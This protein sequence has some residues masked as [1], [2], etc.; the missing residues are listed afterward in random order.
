VRFTIERIRT[1][2]LVAGALLLVA[3]AGFLWVGKW[4]NLLNRGDLPQ[5]LGVNIQQEA[6]GYTF[7]HAYG[8]HSQ[9][10]I[11]ASKEVQLK[12]NRVVLHDVQIE[13]Y[14]QDGKDIDRI[15]GETFEYDEK[16]GVATAQGPV[17]MLLTRPAAAP[18]A[19]AKRK[20]LPAAGA[21]SSSQVYSSQIHVKTSGVTFD[22]NSGMVTTEQQVDFSMTQGYG[23]AMGAQY[24]SQSGHLTLDQ[25]V[26]LT[27]YRGGDTVAIHAQHAEID[28]TTQLCLLRAATADYRGGQAGAAEAKLLFRTEGSA[29][30]LDTTGGF[31]LATATG[32]RLAAPVGW[33]EF[34]EHN[35][36][37][38]G[39]M[40]GGVTMDSVNALRTVHG[41]SPTAELEFT[42]AGQLR[43]AHLER[44]VAIDSQETGPETHQDTSHEANTPLHLNRTWRSPVADMDFR[45]AGQGRVELE[46]MKGTGGVAITSESRRGN[47][48]AAPSK[49]TANEVTGAFGPDSAL[50]SMTGVGHAGIEQTTATGA[51]QTGSGDRLQVE[52][53]QNREQGNKG[54]REQGSMGEAAT[55]GVSEVQSAELDGHVV[56][57][58]Q[59]AAKPGA[60]PQPAMHA[61]AGK[62]VYEGT[63]EWLHLTLSPRV[64][65]G[66]LELT[67]DKV[68]VSEQTGD[69]FAH[70]NVK[71]TWTSQGATAGDGAPGAKA[72]QNTGQG[73]VV[74]GAQGP[75]HVIAEEAQLHQSTGEATFRGH[76]RL[77]QQANSVSGPLIVLDRQKQTLVAT[78]KDS[79]DPVKAVLLSTGAAAGKTA[80]QPSG[81]NG[82]G[83]SAAK[84]ATP[85]VIRVRGG[86]LWYSDTERRAVMHGGVLGA[87]VADTGTATSTSNDVELRLMP[88][89]S[90]AGN[91]GGQAQVDRMTATGRV[92]LTSQ[93][94]RGT[95]EQLVYTGATGDYVLTGTSSTPPKMS[96]P[97]R[98][99]VSGEALIFHSRDDSVS[100]EGGGRE[101]TTET[102]APRA[103]RK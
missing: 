49:M 61:W 37:R 75:A 88:A 94:R 92:T 52:F 51:R 41:T 16:S 1:L 72:G 24:D 50:R 91:N 31:T 83:N 101:T 98:G 96:D 46:A 17:E 58:E 60:Q 89:G 68:D 18:A 5:R 90:P 21:G 27:T 44:G 100:I 74:L 30:R 64:E 33:I 69:A 12:N 56:L 87:V 35:Q 82:G 36:P 3:L 62:A 10:K 53:T 84:T 42:A 20:N 38:H 76:A 28:R 29:Q 66:G 34:D 32:G 11:H 6:N 103:Q 45:D 93:A 59:A 14:G 55:S 25:A 26:E 48:A 67:A 13:L 2:V 63:G 97:E 40:E 71:A 43:H 39:H 78:T 86:D 19:G 15:T 102:T 70:G 9:Y 57:F 73:N 23:S 81:Q 22:R 77:W 80:G 99:S 8:A 79:A 47:E 7:V 54:T 65:D 4:K 95:G 85:S